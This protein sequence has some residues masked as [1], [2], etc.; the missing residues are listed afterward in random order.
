MW[1]V[2]THVLNRDRMFPGNVVDRNA[3]GGGDC[4]GGK[5]CQNFAEG[6]AGHGDL[7]VVQAPLEP[8]L[9]FLVEAR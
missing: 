4:E 8:V 3:Q 5:G 1:T 7:L 6:C 9:G 2:A